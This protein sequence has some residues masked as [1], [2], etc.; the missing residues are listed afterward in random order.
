MPSAI[1]VQNWKVAKW[2][3]V[4][5][6]H[7]SLWYKYFISLASW[8]IR[9]SSG[10]KGSGLNLQSRKPMLPTDNSSTVW[11]HFHLQLLVDALMQSD[12]EKWSLYQ[13]HILMQF[14]LAGT[15]S[16]ISLSPW[17]SFVQYELQ[18]RHKGFKVTTC[19]VGRCYRF[20]AYECLLSPASGQIWPKVFLINSRQVTWN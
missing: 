3:M 20:M 10:W 13:K 17:W 1:V 2:P 6:L 16:T 12:F 14:T 19:Y 8:T 18:Y 5:S 9:D 4:S 11:I 15:H 7:F